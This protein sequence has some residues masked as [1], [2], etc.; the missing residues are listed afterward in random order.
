MKKLQI[1]LKYAELTAMDQWLDDA[2]A[3]MECEKGWMGSYAERC[4]VAVLRQWQILK[5]K[6]K[7]HYA[8]DKQA[9]YTLPAPVSLALAYMITISNLPVASY[10]G[11]CLRQLQ[12]SIYKAYPLP[13]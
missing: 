6:P 7:T 9:C 1:K 12:S 3:T 11:N 4:C 13:S 2:L 10:L 8:F 5:L